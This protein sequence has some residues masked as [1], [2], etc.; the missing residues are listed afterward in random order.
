MA[1]TCWAVMARPHLPHLTA[2]EEDD[3]DDND[4]H[5]AAAGEKRALIVTKAQKCYHAYALQFPVNEVGL[6]PGLPSGRLSLC[7]SNRLLML[8]CCSRSLLLLSSSSFPLPIRAESGAS[9]AGEGRE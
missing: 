2:V 1:C 3:E 9:V 4:D 7:S 5:G 6:L 8:F